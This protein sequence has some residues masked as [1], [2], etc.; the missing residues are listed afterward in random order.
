MNKAWV[1]ICGF[2]A[3]SIVVL[4]V[5]FNVVGPM[6]HMG[7]AAFHLAWPLI[8]FGLLFTITR[9]PVLELWA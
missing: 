2:V 5:M 3:Y 6:L 1:W 4:L 8:I 7:T 9:P